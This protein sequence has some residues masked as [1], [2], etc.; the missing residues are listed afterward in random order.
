M[1]QK[2]KIK[3]SKLIK[4]AITSGLAL[5]VIITI[6]LFTFGRENKKEISNVEADS[7][8]VKTSDTGG[9]VI[10]LSGVT[11]K[12]S[13]YDYTVDGTKLEVIAIKAADGSI[14]TA[15][16]TC[17]VCYSSG[18]GY[19]V[20]QGDYLVCQNCGNRF[21]ASDV[22]VSKGGCNPVP[23]FSENKT[24]DASNITISNSFLQKSK[25]IFEN[26]KN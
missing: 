3:S 2:K 16:N 24:V 18:K 22:E 17:Q 10:P 9:L 19:Y 12:A 5:L 20:Q 25:K 6:V 11:E 8:T 23:I 1:Y 21:K 15:F 14:R 26:W 7:N 13:I 4:V